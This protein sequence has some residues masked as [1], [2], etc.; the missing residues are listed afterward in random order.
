MSIV[1]I[2]AFPLTLNRSPKMPACSK[3]QKGWHPYEEVSPRYLSKTPDHSRH[4][5]V[6]WHQQLSQVGCPINRCVGREDIAEVWRASY[7]LLLLLSGSVRASSTQAHLAPEQTQHRRSFP[8]PLTSTAE[9]AALNA[10]RCW[11]VLLF[12]F[13]F[14]NIHILCWKKQCLFLEFVRSIFTLVYKTI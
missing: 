14:P 11:H 8:S 2:S 10:V 3:T 13:P 4:A 9:K 1:I 7:F 12:L 5:M 6:C